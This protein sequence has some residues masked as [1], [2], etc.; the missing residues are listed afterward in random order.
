MQ[1]VNSLLPQRTAYV[2]IAFSDA[3]F[4]IVTQMPEADAH[5]FSTK[6][7]VPYL[8]AIVQVPSTPWL[9]LR[10]CDM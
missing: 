4:A 3:A 7:R 10:V 8:A 9:Q 2:P 1:R 5:V 6:A